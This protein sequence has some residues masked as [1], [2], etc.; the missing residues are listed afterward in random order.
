VTLPLHDE[1]STTWL[2]AASLALASTLDSASLLLAAL[3]AS[4]RAK[5]RSL[6]DLASFCSFLRWSAY[7]DSDAFFAL[8]SGGCLDVIGCSLL[9]PLAAELEALSFE[10][11]A[12]LLADWV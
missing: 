12:F 4:T 1:L 6:S 7:F 8:D 10:A 3:S 2:P 9:L 5:I 11:P